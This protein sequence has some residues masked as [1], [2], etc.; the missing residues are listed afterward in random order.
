MIKTQLAK[1]IRTQG[2]KWVEFFED[3]AQRGGVPTLDP[4]SSVDF[5]SVSQ[6]AEEVDEPCELVEVALVDPRYL[7]ALET[8]LRRI[9]DFK[10]DTL[11]HY[12]MIL[13]I[14]AIAQDAIEPHEIV[15]SAE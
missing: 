11:D 9:K 15:L 12:D 10:S 4:E 8:A 6:V 3:G 1:A 5:E 2:G 14:Q 7:E 13:T